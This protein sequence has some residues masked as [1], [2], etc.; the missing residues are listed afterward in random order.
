MS[1]DQETYQSFRIPVPEEF[2][3]VFSHFYFAA[4]TSKNNITKTLLPSFQTMMVFNFGTPALFISKEKAKINIGN[5]IVLGPVKQAFSYT[6]LP[7]TQ[8]LIANFK[9]DAFYRFFGRPHLSGDQTM[10]P[11]ELLLDN[12]FHYLWQQLNEIDDVAEK[13]KFILNFC[14][15]YLR[16]QDDV[17]A[18][19]FHF[20]S[21]PLNPVKSVAEQTGHS[22]RNIQLIHKKHFGFSAKEL[23]RY[24]RFIKAIGFIQQL[25][26]S[27]G[28][29]NW[30]EIIEEC[31]YYDQSQLIHDFK[32]FIN[33]SPKKFLN[34][35]RDVCRAS[36][37]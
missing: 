22:E 1:T 7:G 23:S 34:F 8:L 30:F 25:A 16:S 26:S 15:P 11:D 28:K 10:D 21:G 29:V 36:D 9:A 5:C 13:V 14:K 31:G 17:A 4:N 27:T 2:E 19:L 20:Q 18:L 3:T 32:H 35:Q 37:G 12:C 6:L 24:E 33:T